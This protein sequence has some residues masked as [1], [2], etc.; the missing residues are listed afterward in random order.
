MRLKI[1]RRL[2]NRNYWRTAVIR[3]TGNGH[4]TKNE[5]YLLKQVEKAKKVIKNENS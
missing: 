2:V 1:A 4:R 5:K 3:L